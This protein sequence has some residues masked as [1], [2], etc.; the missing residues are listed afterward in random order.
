MARPRL[1][2]DEVTERFYVGLRPQAMEMLRHFAARHG[3][4]PNH[5]QDEVR[6]ALDLYIAEATLDALDDPDF[7]AQIAEHREDFDAAEVRTQA[8]RD[9][10]DAREHAFGRKRR[11]AFEEIAPALTRRR[12]R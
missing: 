9:V 11:P 7:V 10:H 4:D 12:K 2:R 5:I 3:R 6:A 1:P 8:E